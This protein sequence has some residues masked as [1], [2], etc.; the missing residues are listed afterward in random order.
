MS[1]LR[2]FLGL[3]GWFRDFIKDYAAHTNKLTD[4]LSQKKFEWAEE[5]NLQFE[6]TKEQLRNMKKLRI[7][8]Y[9]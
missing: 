1:E 6:G 3:S 8:D 5:M 7:A 2:R 4:P 9:K